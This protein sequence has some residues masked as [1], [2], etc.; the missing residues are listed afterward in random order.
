M[1]V[2]ADPV[3][4]AFQKA[5]QGFKA[6]LQDETIYEEILTV[7]SID[8]V[9]DATDK[10][11]EEQ[12]KK[13][14]LR[15]LSKIEP[16]LTRLN[17]YAD[18]LGVF[19]QVKPDVLALVWGPIVL[20]LQWANALKISF[21]AIVNATA[22][23]GVALPEFRRAVQLFGQNDHIADLLFLFF[24]DILHFYLLALK[25]FKLPREYCI[26]MILNRPLSSLTC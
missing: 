2:A 8:Q 16:Y 26:A 17:E 10:L 25:F 6:D 1:S 21:D 18:A 15:H 11:Q 5:I 3:E 23:I 14:H 13:G 4:D 12:G 9:Y 20:L 24:K 7:N 19:I 22:E